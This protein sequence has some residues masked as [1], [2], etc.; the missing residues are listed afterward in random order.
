MNLKR[1][2][3]KRALACLE[4]SERHRQVLGLEMFEEMRGSRWLGERSRFGALLG[5]AAMCATSSAGRGRGVAS[6]WMLMVRRRSPNV[7]AHSYLFTS[8]QL[9][10]PT[11]SLSHIASNG[12]GRHWKRTEG[13]PADGCSC[14]GDIRRTPLGPRSRFRTLLGMG[15]GPL[16]G[17]IRGQLM[18]ALRR[19]SCHHTQ[20]AFHGTK[21]NG[22]EFRAGISF[23]RQNRT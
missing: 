14:P 20:L 8:T 11:K 9:N 15:L 12:I 5:M 4:N 2:V 1:L 19:M 23:V 3:A 7:T 10:G 16:S 6:W 17:Q 18:D 22:S 21:S 13:W